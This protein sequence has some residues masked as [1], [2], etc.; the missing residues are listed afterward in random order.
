MGLTTR[1]RRRSRL[2]A[3]TL[4]V[5]TVL[6]VPS[7]ALARPGA[8][9]LSFGGGDGLVTAQLGPALDAA[10]NVASTSDGG[11]IVA[12]TVGRGAIPIAFDL[13]LLALDPTGNPRSGFG[14]A[15]TVVIPIDPSS[16]VGAF[17]SV[18]QRPDGS[19]LVGA[20]TTDSPPKVIV[21]TVSSSGIAAPPT[22]VP[23]PGTFTPLTGLAVDGQGGFVYI[24]VGLGANVVGVA[25]LLPNGAQDLGFGAGG[26]GQQ[27]VDAGPP[28]TGG[29]LSIQGD[30]KPVVAVTGTRADGATHETSAVRFTTGGQP[31]PGFGS[32]GVATLPNTPATPQDA[33]GQ[34]TTSPAGVAIIV[35]RAASSPGESVVRFTTAGQPATSFGG[36]GYQPIG[37]GG[38][39]AP[40][41]LALASD[42]SVIVIGDGAVSSPGGSGQRNSAFA[43]RLNP[44]GSR[45]TTFGDNPLN[46]Y[47]PFASWWNGVTDGYS[48]VASVLT[49]TGLVAVG[50]YTP[51]P[52]VAPPHSQF[53]VARIVTAANQP[54][55]V[56]LGVS[57]PSGTNTATF[58]FTAT[59]HDPD[60]VGAVARYRWDV[61]GNGVVDRVTMTPST[62][63]VYPRAGSFTATVTAFDNEGASSSASARVPVSSAA[64]AAAAALR[65]IR[66]KLTV[67]GKPHRPKR[68]ITDTFSKVGT[69]SCPCQ[70]F[71]VLRG[72]KKLLAVAQGKL[73]KRHTKIPFTVTATRRMRL[74]LA[75]SR[76][77][78]VPEPRR[79]ADERAD[80]EMT[81]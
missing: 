79:R 15:G 29:R 33:A 76:D 12:G 37:N 40:N 35:K 18:A 46:G 21:D 8:L 71:A 59:A 36:T 47:G 27:T 9:D 25:R 38:S 78:C 30:G 70:Y 6:V 43:T 57:P 31:D 13:G 26:I 32:G 72:A 10:Q 42:G 52:P 61:D 7:G 4:A 50:Q 28:T 20:L 1:G 2:T 66:A 65:R 53:A 34:I 24:A 64:A 44:D 45:D 17:P 39:N 14:S 23:A 81:A 68:T 62:T 63:F 16:S 69:A 77:R 49:P 3:A 48:H 74:T 60:P 58:T 75:G 11:L 67:A 54:P 73:D 41:D 19:Y 22:L 5:A 80:Q 55:T 56:S 51:Q